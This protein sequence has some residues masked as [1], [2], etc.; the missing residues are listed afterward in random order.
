[1]DTNYLLRYFKTAWDMLLDIP[2]PLTVEDID[3]EE[4][5]GDSYLLLC[6]PL[7]GAALGVLAYFVAYVLGLILIIPM[8]AAVIVS[9][10]L[11]LATEMTAASSNISVLTSFINAKIAHKNSAELELSLNK[12]LTLDDPL[13]LMLFL[14]LYLLKLFCFGLLIYN[15]K[16]SWIVITFTLSYLIRSQLVTLPSYNSYGAL[17]EEDDERY[18]VKMPWIVAGVIV[19][20]AGASYLASAILILLVAFA[21]ILGFKKYARQ[22]GGVSPSM[23]GVYGVIAEL[24]F[25]FTG[26]AIVIR[27]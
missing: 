7:V 10:V 3:S 15:A 1:M 21:L 19:L 20:F 8:A 25:L 5:D 18:A 14:S 12:K 2:L 23:I 13:S 16:T 9:I 17:I 22:M 6:F 27:S 11:T 4:D 24:V 26:A